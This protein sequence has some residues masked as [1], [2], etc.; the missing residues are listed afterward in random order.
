MAP[1]STDL[2][3]SPYAILGNRNF[4]YYLLGRFMATFGQQ[5][6]TVA[7]GWELYERTGSSLV[8]GLVGLT[9]FLPM[10]VMTLPPATSPTPGNA[11]R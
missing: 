1:P 10:V 11:S 7:V 6:L 9:A 4:L 3:A 2:K 5:M 8:L